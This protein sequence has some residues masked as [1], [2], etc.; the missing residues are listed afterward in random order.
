MC[1]A[2]FI[3]ADGK[4]CYKGPTPTQ[5]AETEAFFLKEF[6]FFFFLAHDDRSIIV[7]S[8]VL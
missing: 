3:F 8:A 4:Y 1:S 5:R 2:Q 7:H 6:F